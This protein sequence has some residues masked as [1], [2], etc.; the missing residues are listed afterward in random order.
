MDAKKL[1]QIAAFVRDERRLDTAFANVMEGIESD[2]I[3][4]SDLPISAAPVKRV[5]FGQGEAEYAASMVEKVSG[6]HLDDGQR[7]ALMSVVQDMPSDGAL[8]ALV[9]EVAKIEALSALAEGLKEV[10]KTGIYDSL[11]TQTES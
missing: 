11:F 4:A 3:A 5:T 6:V 8:S 2:A 7:N 10:Q 1:S 9:A